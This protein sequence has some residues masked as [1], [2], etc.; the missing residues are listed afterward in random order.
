MCFYKYLRQVLALNLDLVGLILEQDC[1]EIAN[2]Q[3]ITVSRSCMESGIVCF[4]LLLGSISKAG[5]PRSGFM[6]HRQ[7]NKHCMQSSFQADK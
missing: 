3:S 5:N 1:P 4:E 7:Q 6:L 2:C